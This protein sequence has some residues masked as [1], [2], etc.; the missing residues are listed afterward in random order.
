MRVGVLLCTRQATTT[1]HSHACRPPC[2]F[3]AANEE[4]EKLRAE[5]G[6][7]EGEVRPCCV[8]A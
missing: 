1:L 6:A 8:G 3:N 5:V 4:I 2:R 7:K